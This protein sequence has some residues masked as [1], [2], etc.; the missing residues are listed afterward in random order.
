VNARRL[1]PPENLPMKNAHDLARAAKQRIQEVPLDQAEQAVREADEF[2]AG[3]LATACRP[4]AQA[5][6]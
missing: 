3:Q 1:P 4:V 6:S 2:A 5:F